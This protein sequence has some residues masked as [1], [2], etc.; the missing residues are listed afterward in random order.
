MKSLQACIASALE[1]G[2]LQAAITA[3]ELVVATL[4]NLDAQQVAEA[5]LLAQSCRAVM[6]MEAIYSIAAAPQVGPLILTNKDRVCVAFNS[7]CHNDCQP[8]LDAW[9][10][11]MY[12]HQPYIFRGAQLCRTTIAQCQTATVSMSHVV[13]AKF[14]YKWL[15]LCSLA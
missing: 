7:N 6:Q 5:L 2:G 1:A 9:G 11:P 14:C 4:G 8:W 15:W 13:A 10:W 12:Q 3:A